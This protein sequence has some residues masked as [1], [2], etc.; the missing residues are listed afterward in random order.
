MEDHKRRE[1][2]KNPLKEIW[3]K[4]TPWVQL[5]GFAIL[6][7]FTIGQNY[8]KFEAHAAAIAMQS[9]KIDTMEARLSMQERTSAQINQKLDDMI[10]YFKVPH[11]QYK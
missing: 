5:I 10:L 8:S 3:E 7:V 1:Y 4:T 11:N 6:F 2:D 9:A